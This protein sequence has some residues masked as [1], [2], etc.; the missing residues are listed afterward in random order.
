[1]AKKP[2]LKELEQKVEE[3]KIA[4]EQSIIYA[5]E[6]KGEIKDRKKA[7][8]HF[9]LAVR[10]KAVDYAVYLDYGW[11]KYTARQWQDARKM[12]YTA[13]AKYRGGDPKV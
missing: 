2:T 3:L 13:S 7:E 12:F 5:K 9:E 8:D 4:Y 10:Y 6:L 11:I 1:M